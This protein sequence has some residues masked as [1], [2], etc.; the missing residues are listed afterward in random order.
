MSHLRGMTSRRTSFDM[1][2]ANHKQYTCPMHP[3]VTSDQPGK[4]PKCGGMDLIQIQKSEDHTN[5][6]MD[7]SG[8]KGHNHQEHDHSMMMAGPEVAKD[9]LRRFFIVTGLLIPLAI[10]SQPGI[11]LL[12]YA[13]FPFREY[14][15][16]GLASNRGLSGL[17]GTHQVM[18]K[19]L[20][21]AKG[22]VSKWKPMK[23]TDKQKKRI[24]IL[25][26]KGAMAHGYSTELWTT[27][28]I[29]E[30]IK[31]H[32]GITYHRD[33]IGRLMASLGWSYQK[34]GKRPLQRNEQAIE[35]WKRKAWPRIKKTPSG[36]APT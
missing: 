32:F 22:F 6:Q 31:R 29:A 34:P 24:V 23:L 7:H 19:Q 13:D 36:W 12:G 26:L 4:C 30:L 10:F 28:R 16:F 11:K 27:A 8:H 14:L 20:G 15:E 25:L 21:R 33:H 9:F 17:F 18:S 5:H 1:K 35:Q 2:H 3:E